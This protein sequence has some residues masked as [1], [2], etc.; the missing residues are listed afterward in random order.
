LSYSFAVF[1]D[2]G[3]EDW[4]LHLV[5]ADLWAY[6]DTLLTAA[7]NLKQLYCIEMMFNAGFPVARATALIFSTSGER[8]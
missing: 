6:L 2:S 5:Q 3:A 8:W 1:I 7:A 4:N